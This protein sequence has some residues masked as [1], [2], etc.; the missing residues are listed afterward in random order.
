[1][2][3]TSLQNRLQLEQPHRT[4]PTATLTELVRRGP[5]VNS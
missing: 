4:I 1:L 3:L 2:S 5:F